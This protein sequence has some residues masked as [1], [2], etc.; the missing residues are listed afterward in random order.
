MNRKY[1]VQ[2]FAVL[3][4]LFMLSATT[5]LA[6]D[7]CDK[8]HDKYQVCVEAGVAGSNLDLVDCA[9]YTNQSACENAGCYWNTQG[10]PPPGVFQ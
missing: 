5:V 2:A 10:L 9:T 6:Q 4:C 8:Y 1:L 7:L 3:P